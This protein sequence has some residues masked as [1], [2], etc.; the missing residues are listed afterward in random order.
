MLGGQYE[1]EQD[2]DMQGEPDHMLFLDQVKVQSQEDD[3]DEHIH[4]QSSS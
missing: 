3:D 1:V 2:E 4:N